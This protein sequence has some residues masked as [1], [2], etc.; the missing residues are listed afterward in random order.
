MSDPEFRALVREMRNQQ[1]EYFRLRR[2][3]YSSE[4][5]RQDAL[6][7]AKSLEKRVDEELAGNATGT[8]EMQP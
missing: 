8:L 4:V 6:S 5:Q 7:L 2:S 1:K 3:S